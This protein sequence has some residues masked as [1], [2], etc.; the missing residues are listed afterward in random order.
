MRK[1]IG[2]FAICMVM[3]VVAIT[4]AAAY[5]PNKENV[6]VKGNKYIYEYV[7]QGIFGPK[8]SSFTYNIKTKKVVL[9]KSG[10]VDSMWADVENCR[11]AYEN[12]LYLASIYPEHS[13]ALVNLKNKY[14]D[15]DEKLDA[16]IKAQ[17]GVAPVD[18]ASSATYQRTK[19]EEWKNKVLNS[20][21]F[22]TEK[23]WLYLT[24]AE[25]S[26]ML[27]DFCNK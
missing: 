4:K 10:T 20:Y 13:N 23:N 19:A 5:E 17:S 11:K 14:G 24:K 15:V 7:Y 9:F 3:M 18:D 27:S 26:K 16:L 25:W 1:I 12:C 22:F 8:T 21:P 6:T 2:M